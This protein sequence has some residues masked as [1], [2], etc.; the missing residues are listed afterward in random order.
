MKKG[1]SYNAK[2]VPSSA[3]NAKAVPSSAYAKHTI[4]EHIVPFN[5]TF[6][7]D[8]TVEKTLL[9]IQKKIGSWPNTESI[10]VLDSDNKLLGFAELKKLLSAKPKETL[11]NVM[12]NDFD[13]LTDRPHQNTAIKLAIKERVESI[14]VTDQNGH[15][16]GI[17]DAGQILKIMHE[18]HIEKLMRFSGVVNSETFVDA[19]KSKVAVSVRSRLPWLLLGLTGGIVSTFIIQVFDHTLEEEL[20][21]AFF[22]PLV[23]YI[24]AA[25][26]YQTQTIFVRSITFDKI[27]LLKVLLYEFKVGIIV[28]AIL[29]VATFVIS[30]FW[31]GFS[32]SEIVALSMFG[33]ILTSVLLGVLIPWLLEKAG[34]DPAIGSG[35]FTTIVQDL[36]SVGVYFSIASLLL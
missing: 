19:Y 11:G 8:E 23:V 13:F 36:I 29:S 21:L 12:D 20:A 17:I 14:P 25:V 32:V 22:I 24:N 34:K 18:E 35:P 26:G 27:A 9:F 31:I 7:K 15:F 6:S 10:F 33:G 5:L 16:L 4:G 28:G 30:S 3:Y 1:L 2:A